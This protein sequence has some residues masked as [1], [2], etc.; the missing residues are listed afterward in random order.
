MSYTYMISYSLSSGELK[1]ET[2]SAGSVEEAI[3]LFKID[4]GMDDITVYNIH[5][6][7]IMIK[8]FTGGKMD[9]NK[10]AHNL[11]PSEYEEE[12]DWVRNVQYIRVEF[13]PL[14]DKKQEEETDSLARHIEEYMYQKFRGSIYGSLDGSLVVCTDGFMRADQNFD[15]IELKGSCTN[16][17][18]RGTGDNEP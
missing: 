3:G 16:Y 15:N 9:D 11:H 13:P 8:E 4:M 17:H 18:T 7:W 10:T 12:P 6:V 14:E 1:H 2:I 5:S